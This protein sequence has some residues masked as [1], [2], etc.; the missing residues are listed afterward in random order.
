M[1][2]VC[3]LIPIWFQLTAARR[4]LVVCL[5]I[6]ITYIKFQLTAAR[7]RLVTQQLQGLPHYKVSTHSRPKAAGPAICWIHCAADVST[8]SR[9]K[10]AGLHQ[11]HGAHVVEVSTHSRPKAAG[12]SWLAKKYGRLGFNSQ[13]PEGGWQIFQ[14]DFGRRQTV[15]TH[16][17]PKAAG[18]QAINL[19]VIKHVSTH[20]RPKA[21]GS[22]FAKH[23]Q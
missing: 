14:A 9:P 8:H 18:L 11:Q 22:A 19:T 21:A 16:S 2:Q 7:R 6:G 12:K 13:P 15:S 1:I 20:S 5:L 4:R 3:R 23:R 17:R 10:A